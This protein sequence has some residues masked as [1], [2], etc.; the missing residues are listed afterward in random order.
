LR[1]QSGC[2]DN[3]ENST[4]FAAGLASPRNS[5]APAATCP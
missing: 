2:V 4:D 3:N 1:V 5:A